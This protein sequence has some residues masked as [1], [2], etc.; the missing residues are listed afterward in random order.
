[1]ETFNAYVISLNHAAPL[2]FDEGRSFSFRMTIMNLRSADSP[3]SS[4]ESIQR[5]LD[6]VKRLKAEN[7]KL[8]GKV[9]VDL[10]NSQGIEEY[11]HFSWEWINCNDLPKQLGVL[12]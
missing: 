11:Y 3:A 9:E 7:Q 4:T 1:M 10:S 2:Q 6:E 5:L 8:R 12:L